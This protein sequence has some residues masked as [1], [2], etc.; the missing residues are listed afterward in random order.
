MSRLLIGLSVGSGLEGVDA[1]AIRADG[2]A[3]DLAPVVA[4]AV[5]VAFPPAVRDAVRAAPRG[6]CWPP[7][8]SSATSPRR[9]F[10]VPGKC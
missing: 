2:I 7:P 10:T 1:V 4:A 3:L 6:R 8:N 5:R 9:R